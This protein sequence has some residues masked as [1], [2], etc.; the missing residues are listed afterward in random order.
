M[1]VTVDDSK[2]SGH[3]MCAI[4]APIV[5][6]SDDYGNAVVLTN[7]VPDEQQAPARRAEANCPERAIT[8]AEDAQP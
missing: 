8:I 4:A 6:G 7:P 2:C 5:F 3:Q 1:R